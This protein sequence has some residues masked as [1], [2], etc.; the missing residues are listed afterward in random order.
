MMSETK[1]DG[2]GR[3]GPLEYARPI[4][5]R[6]KSIGWIV[7]WTIAGLLAVFLAI[8]IFLPSGA[9]RMQS[10]RVISAS[11]LKQ[12][13]LAM[14]LYANDHH[15]AFPDSLS[16]ILATEDLTPGVFVSPLSNDTPATGPTTQA[17]LAVFA[18]PE[19][20]SYLY[21]GAGLS[22][23]GDPS[24]VT[25][26]EVPQPNATGMNVFFL[27]GHVEFVPDP[28]AQ[29]LRAALAAGPVAWASAGGITR[30]ATQPT[31]GP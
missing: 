15:D 26:C 6:R 10:P 11:N 8:T 13:G 7:G 17:T 23:T 19:H 18:T 1:D 3:D 21:F 30:P 16:T 22:S 25:A 31:T 28:A 29:Q 12:I 24:T 4:E 20:C 5:R 27:D 2:G 9:S 14:F